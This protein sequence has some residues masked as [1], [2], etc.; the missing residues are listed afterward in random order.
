MTFKFVAT[1]KTVRKT[2]K[3]TK[4]KWEKALKNQGSQQT[5][6]QAM[7]SKINNLSC[8]LQSSV[9]KIRE[10]IIKLDSIA[11]KTAATNSSAYIQQMIETEKMNQKPGY[12]D[13]VKELEIQQKR[14]EAFDKIAHGGNI[15]GVEV[16][17]AVTKKN[18]SK[19]KQVTASESYK[20][21]DKHENEIKSKFDAKVPKNDN[22]SEFTQNYTKQTDVPFEDVMRKI[23]VTEQKKLQ[24]K[25]TKNIETMLKKRAES[26]EMKKL[27][28]LDNSYS[29]RDE[30]KQHN[31]SY[32]QKNEGIA[33]KKVEVML[34]KSSKHIDEIKGE[35]EQALFHDEK[36]SKKKSQRKTF[37]EAEGNEKGE[38]SETVNQIKDNGETV[39]E[40][41]R[42]EIMSNQRTAPIEKHTKQNFEMRKMMV[43]KLCEALE[44]TH[45][46]EGVII[47]LLKDKEWNPRKLKKLREINEE[48]MR[49]QLSIDVPLQSTGM[50]DLVKQK[51]EITKKLQLIIFKL[52]SIINSIESE[53]KE[54]GANSEVYAEDNIEIGPDIA[55]KEESRKYDNELTVTSCSEEEEET[56]I[57][58]TVRKNLIDGMDISAMYAMCL[59]LLQ[60]ELHEELAKEVYEEEEFFDAVEDLPADKEKVQE[61]EHKEENEEL[62]I[63][64][65]EQLFPFD[66]L[67]EKQKETLTLAIARTLDSEIKDNTD[68]EIV[69][70]V[71]SQMYDMKL[72]EKTLLHFM[73]CFLP[74]EET[75]EISLVFDGTKESLT[76]VLDIIAQT[77]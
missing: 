10:C 69:K 68:Y 20:G 62:E 35:E 9:N 77:N 61:K 21:Y 58:L 49:I 28:E 60:E 27:E 39:T 19:V 64:R 75:D 22:S 73:N 40:E 67:S 50:D 23:K 42:K 59:K 57:E 38:N 43:F 30:T 37:N 71:V 46:V 36:Q 3:E 15:G 2:A 44:R 14:A 24:T 76:A 16:V 18:A 1:N 6:V 5:V 70:S 32:V 48:A 45:K 65:L 72:E 33:L 25:I 13:K 63:K 17:P 34:V 11:L 51:I 26:K 74:K 47:K 31:E 55:L 12:L 7:E 53:R 56:S 8:E 54:E 29:K 66:D 41:H 52:D 4:E